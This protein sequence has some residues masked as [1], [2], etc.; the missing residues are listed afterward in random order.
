MIIIQIATHRYSKRIGLTNKHDAFLPLSLS[1]ALSFTVALVRKM[2]T[3]T[4]FTHPIDTTRFT[5]ESCVATTE[6]SSLKNGYCPD[7]A[8]TKDISDCIQIQKLDLFGMLFVYDGKKLKLSSEKGYTVERILEISEKMNALFT[9]INRK[10][11]VPSHFTLRPI[12]ERIENYLK[13]CGY[14][15]KTD[16]GMNENT[17]TLWFNL[18]KLNLFHIT[19]EC[20]LIEKA[21]CIEEEEAIARLTQLENLRDSLLA[22]LDPFIRLQIQKRGITITNNTYTGFDTEYTLK[23]SAKHLNKL[24]SV[25]CAVQSRV[26]IKIPLYHRFDISYVHPLTSDITNYYTPRN[27]YWGEGA[28][29]DNIKSL[30]EMNLLNDSLKSCVD[31]YRS[32]NFSTHDEINRNLISLLEDVPGVDFFEDFTKDYVV[33]A[34]PISQMQSN[35]TYPDAG[36][37]LKTLVVTSNSMSLDN[38]IEGLNVLISLLSQLK[39]T[40]EINKI[41]AWFKQDKKARIRTTLRFDSG[42]K[43][44]LTVVKNNYLI[45]HYN[46]ADLCL[47]SDFHS[48]KTELNIVQKSFV[49]LTKPIVIEDSNIYIRD[50]HLLTP[51]S[52]KSLAALGKLYADDLECEKIE[53]LKDDLEHM[54]E[55]LV[56][57]PIAFKQYAIRDAIIPLKHAITLERVNFSIKRIGIPI[58]LSS[59]GRSLVL[60]K[61]SARFEKFFPYQ[62]SGEVLMGNA[63]EIQT[64]K[65]LFA[66][67][68]VGLYLGHYIGNYKGGRNESYM[69]GCDEQTEWYDYDLASAYSTAMTYLTLP[70]YT[71]ARILE[72][73]KVEAMTYE[74]LLKGYLILSGSFKFP[75]ETKYPSI[76][77][78]A[79]KTTTV[80]PLTGDCI[81]T[82]PEYLL[83]KQ[84]KCVVTIK[85]AFYIPS[86][87]REKSFG[88]V[89][90]NIPVTPFAEIIQYL[91]DKRRETPKGHVLNALYKELTNSIYGNVV[92]GIADKRSFDAQTGKTL[93]VNATELSN[94]ILA[95][96]TTAFIRSVIGECLD[97]IH[98]LG[99]KIVSTTTDGFIT[100]IPNLETILSNLSPESTPLLTLFRNLR[101][102]LSDDI[103]NHIALELKSQCTG[104]ISWSTRG[105]LGITGGIR[106]A[107]GFQ[108]QGYT[109]TEMVDSFKSV[110]ACEDKSIDYTQFRLRSAKDIFKHGGH[111]TSIYRDQK[112]RLIYD[113]RRSIVEPSNYKNY[114][115]SLTLLDS[116]PFVTKEECIKLRFLSKFPL[117][118][119]YMQRS[120]VKKVSSTL[121]RNYL[122]I[123]V[124]NFIKGY[125]ATEPQFGLAGTEFKW[126]NDLITF[127][128]GFNQTK[129]IKISKQSVSKLKTRKSMIRPVPNTRENIAFAAY[130]KSHL[131]NFDVQSF[132][133]L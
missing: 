55:Y 85:S 36:Y 17:F 102:A 101:I 22:S 76:P 3:R 111:V 26:F 1:L 78:Y 46:A 74:Q 126:Y 93:R 106:A 127:I 99:G 16:F 37:T 84:Q 103:K 21:S 94:P 87:Y 109:T 4:F 44:A 91:Q 98:K 113:N 71:A 108:S 81:L 35:I 82:G 40:T 132:L 14:K 66:S 68:N 97:N 92:R 50:T 54:D 116:K 56:R 63:H 39:L 77:C 59:L 124:R 115:M 96:W 62:V 86:T 70:D 95:S 73:S 52:G 12:F 9:F 43:F 23:N 19:S 79:D 75:P 58:T 33:F 25:Q 27:Q 114:D 57:E 13:S 32:S 18:I 8:V 69:Y 128:Y 10:G 53:I 110:L 48:L 11:Y 125:L 123:G 49:T 64:P 107:T 30:V 121:Y 2:G 118:N 130:V 29:I 117:K 7:T 6:V 72:A 105:Q 67:G 131:P 42:D 41:K 15:V 28:K 112:V 122:E 20:L 80:Y 129:I 88:K 24:V 61:W 51:A 65:G 31:S 119:P 34:L 100:N 89:V 133:K 120:P 60:E 90:V 38:F 45:G 5:P 104:I 47:F 83:A